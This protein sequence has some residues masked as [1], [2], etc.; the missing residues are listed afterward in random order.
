MGKGVHRVG[1]AVID[2]N[3]FCFRVVRVFR[4]STCL[5]HVHILIQ[6]GEEAANDREGVKEGGLAEQHILLLTWSDGGTR[7]MSAGNGIKEICHSDPFTVLSTELLRMPR[8]PLLSL[9]S[10]NPW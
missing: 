5:F 2:S 6:Q 7:P 1:E 4:G 3:P 8:S 9:P 10:R